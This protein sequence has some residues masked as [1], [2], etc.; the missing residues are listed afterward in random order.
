[1]TPA[2]KMFS[3]QFFKESISNVGIVVFGRVILFMELFP[4]PFLA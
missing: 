2:S 1:M 4:V 3:P